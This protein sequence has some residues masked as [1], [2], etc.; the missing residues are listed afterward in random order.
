MS[1]RAVRNGDPTTTGGVVIADMSTM[2]NHGKQVALDGDKATCGN[3]E[4]TFLIVGSAQRM[5]NR[6]RCVALEGD[7]V[8]CPCG[9]N[10]LVAGSDSTI[11]Y[12]D[13]GYS[14]AASPF[15]ARSAFATTTRHA[16]ASGIH[17]EQYI[18]R[19][20]DSGRPLA[21]VRYRIL[22]SSGNVFTGVTDATGHTQRVA[23]AYAES[24]KLEI[25]RNIHAES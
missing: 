21:N 19:D 6:G 10:R 22:L 5:T 25:A 14:N 4:G 7:V 15:A 23:S 8:L 13:D 16:P 2:S 24:L 3:C 1:R 11:L 17:D 20:A 9:Q 18:L 12:R